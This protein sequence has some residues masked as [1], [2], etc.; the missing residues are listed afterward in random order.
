MVL[1]KLGQ[2]ASHF[3]RKFIFI[4]YLIFMLYKLHLT[5]SEQ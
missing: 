2:L 1:D 4:Y 5:I 3:S